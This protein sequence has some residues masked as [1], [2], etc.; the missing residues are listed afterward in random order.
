MTLDLPE[1]SATQHHALIILNVPRPYAEGNDF[2]GVDFAINANGTVVAE[3]GFTYSTKRPD[4]FGRMPFTL[5]VR[6]ELHNGQHTHVHAQWRSV[7]ASTGH[8]DSFA[9]FSAVLG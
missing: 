8:I 2:P 5:V 1:A 6:V 3:G 9:S 4:A 7:R